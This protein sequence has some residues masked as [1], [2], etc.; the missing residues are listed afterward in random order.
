MHPEATF[1][2]GY[3]FSLTLIAVGL[4]WLVRRSTDPWTSRTLAACRPPTERPSHDEPD[5]PHSEVPAFHLGLAAVALVA[6][7][8]LATVS[9]V[10]VVGPVEFVV[11]MALL[12]IVGVGRICP[13]GTRLERDV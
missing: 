6:A 13:D 11:H 7:L 2:A 3:S 1:L 10:R 4:E 12:A 5:W 9:A 8:V